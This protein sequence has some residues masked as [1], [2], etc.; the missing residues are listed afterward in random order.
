MDLACRCGRRLL[1]RPRARCTSTGSRALDR[2][3][4]WRKSRRSTAIT[5]GGATRRKPDVRTDTSGLARSRYGVGFHRSPDRLAAAETWRRFVERNAT[6]RSAA[7]LPPAVTESVAAW[8]DFLMH[9]HLTGDPRGFAVDQ[10]TPAQ[11]LVA[12]GACVELLRRGLRV[13]SAQRVARR[14][15]EGSG[16]ALWQRA[17][18]AGDG[19]RMGK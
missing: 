19:P 10:L 4:T 5:H 18:K 3:R 17:L 11:V 15:P 16:D 13:L 7:G 6:V 2:C 14:G 12:R 1:L 9:G 8:D